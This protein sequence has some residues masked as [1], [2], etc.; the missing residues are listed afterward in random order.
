MK[1][2]KVPFAKCFTRSID[3]RAPK[4]V[5]THKIKMNT[6]MAQLNNLTSR[7]DKFQ[8]SRSE[9]IFMERLGSDMKLSQ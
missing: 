3:V 6:D 9:I 5:T 1:T 8:C 4:F 7:A 2:F